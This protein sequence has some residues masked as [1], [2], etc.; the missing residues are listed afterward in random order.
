MF[1]SPQIILR[2]I[3]LVIGASCFVFTLTQQPFYF[4]TSL[5]LSCQLWKPSQSQEQP[6]RH[7]F[8]LGMPHWANVETCGYTCDITSEHLTLQSLCTAITRLYI[9]TCWS[10][11]LFILQSSVWQFWLL[12]CKIKEV[13]LVVGNVWSGD[14]HA[15]CPLPLYRNILQNG[16]R[17]PAPHSGDRALHLGVSCKMQEKSGLH[18]PAGGCVTPQG[19]VGGWVP[20]NSLYIMVQKL[21][22]LYFLLLS[23][24]AFHNV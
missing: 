1:S 8:R 6:C 7:L 12:M 15:L 2:S 21:P 13:C 5:N 20:F 24:S 22:V 14:I 23:L 18:Q 3:R 11:H 19:G 10:S 9:N 4:C 17:S 16:G